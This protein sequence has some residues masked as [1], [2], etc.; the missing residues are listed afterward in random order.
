[1]PWLQVDISSDLVGLKTVRPRNMIAGTSYSPGKAFITFARNFFE[2]L[3]KNDYQTALGKLDSSAKRW[4]RR[5]LHLQIDSL[6][7]G[8]GICSALAFKFSASPILEQTVSGYVLRH[9]L[10]VQNKWSDITAVFE[11]TRKPATEY[12]SV[13]LL[14]FET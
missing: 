10:P 14:G 1:V 9:K 6:T 5:E 12:F 4:S 13:T 8:V 7:R 2:A 3:A 11:F